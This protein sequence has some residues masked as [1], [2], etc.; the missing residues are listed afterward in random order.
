MNIAPLS[1]DICLFLALVGI[2]VV[3]QDAPVMIHKDKNVSNSVMYKDK[4]KMRKKF[5]T[6]IP[7]NLQHLDELLVLRKHIVPIIALPPSILCI[8]NIN[9]IY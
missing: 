6:K 8:I 9:K 3:D 2:V 5:S 7:V 1:Q 4:N